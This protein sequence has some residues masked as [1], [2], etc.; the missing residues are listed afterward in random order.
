MTDMKVCNKHLLYRI[1]LNMLL[2]LLPHKK[3]VCTNWKHTSSICSVCKLWKLS[4]NDAKETQ[5]HRHEKPDV[6]PLC[7]TYW[8]IITLDM[9]TL[10]R[11]L[12]VSW[13]EMRSVYPESCG[14][15]LVS[16]KW[17]EKGSEALNHD[18]LKW[19]WQRESLAWN[20]IVSACSAQRVTGGPNDRAIFSVLPSLISLLQWS[21][22]QLDNENRC[23]FAGKAW[24]ENSL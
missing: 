5:S 21:A 2:H 7:C 10:E 20:K 1:T 18:Q 13:K 14:L 12:T 6:L 17:G 16:F 9:T 8:L 15:S 23:T 24:R 22:Q 4:V 11:L 19:W 3:K